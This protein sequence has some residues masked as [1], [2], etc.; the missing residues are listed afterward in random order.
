M[1]KIIN[2]MEENENLR[3]KIRLSK[4]RENEMKIKK[5]LI[6]LCK[7]NKYLNNEI[8]KELNKPKIDDKANKEAIERLFAFEK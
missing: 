4:Q 8:E 7:Q 2:Y 1:E 3:L 5:E 6:L